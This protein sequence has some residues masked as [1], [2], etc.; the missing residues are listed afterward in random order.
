MIR[1]LLPLAVLPVAALALA[2][3]AAPAPSGDSEL[4]I[5]AT[6]SVYGDLAAGVAGDRA[7]VVSIIDSAAQDPHSYELTAR[8]RLELE[9]AD[10]VVSNGGGYDPWAQQVLDSADAAGPSIVAVDALGLSP[11]GDHD[12]AAGIGEADGDAQESAGHDDAGHDHV[13]GFNEHV[14]YDP[15]LM[16]RLVG[17]IADEL[18]RIDPAGSADYAANASALEGELDGL[19]ARAT[20]LVPLADGRGVVVTEPA[21]LRLLELAGLADLTPAGFSEAIEEGGDI[22]P[23]LLQDVLTTL[24]EPEVALVA[25]NVQTG[26]AE[27]DRVETAARAEGVPVLDIG[28]TLPEG[29]GYLAWMGSVIDDLDAALGAR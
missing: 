7:R 23:A 9:T 18:A 2:G 22:A 1:R 15:S 8:D 24:A 19:A 5:V 11:E 29:M 27:T 26:G 28:E 10:L 17:L 13:E 20:A 4:V 14:W 3:C 25:V 21:P 12:E 16:S 6:T